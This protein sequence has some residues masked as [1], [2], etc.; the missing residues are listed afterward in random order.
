MVLAQPEQSIFCL[1]IDPHGCGVASLVASWLRTRCTEIPLDNYMTFSFSL[2]E[3]VRM[4][5][6]SQPVLIF[7][8]QIA[9]SPVLTA[10]HKTH[11]H[12]MAGKKLT[13]C[14]FAT[15]VGLSLVQVV[16]IAVAD[17]QKTLVVFT[18]TANRSRWWTGVM[19]RELIIDTRSC[20]KMLLLQ[21][22]D[23]MLYHNP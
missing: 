1:R 14:L 21:R 5:S 22:Y 23:L 3:L 7:W 16:T 18:Q 4:I 8:E 10:I 2:M 6:S 15:H 17:F 12:I 20:L 11:R 13:G 19:L 9:F